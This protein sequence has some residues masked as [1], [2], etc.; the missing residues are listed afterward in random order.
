MPKPTTGKYSQKMYR[1]SNCGYE[2]LEGTNHWGEIY[3]RCPNCSWKTPGQ[4]SPQI[5]MESPPE[6]IG[7]P[8]PWTTV[9]LGDILKDK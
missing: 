6:G 5:C 8:K 1:C 9:K 3:S 2:R 7:I 4:I